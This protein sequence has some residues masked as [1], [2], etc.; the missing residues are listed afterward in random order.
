ME[1][2]DLIKFSWAS[3]SWVGLII[4]ILHLKIYAK[5]R[6]RPGIPER[7]FNIV[8]WRADRGEVQE[9]PMDVYEM[10]IEVLNESR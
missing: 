1:A 3:G 4:E 5:E 6:V 2:G 10:Q 8:V 7:P 9:W